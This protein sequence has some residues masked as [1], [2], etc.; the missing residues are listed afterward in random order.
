M[1]RP[2]VMNTV[3]IRNVDAA[4][5]GCGVLLIVL[6]YVESKKDDIDTIKVLEYDDTLASIAEFVGIILEGVSSLHSISN[7]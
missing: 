1:P 5:V 6:V 7:L 4:L 3:E 2:H